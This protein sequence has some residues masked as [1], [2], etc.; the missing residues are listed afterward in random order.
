MPISTERSH[1]LFSRAQQLM[2]GGVNSP[3]RA[4]K[5]VGGEPFFRLG[6]GQA[7][8]A[9][10]Q[11]GKAIGCGAGMWVGNPH[12]HAFCWL[13]MAALTRMPV[14]GPPTTFIPS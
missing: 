4:F 12:Q 6:R 10:F 8:E 9:G 2:P 14:F 5:S 7:R 1:D 13:S 3:V 11:I